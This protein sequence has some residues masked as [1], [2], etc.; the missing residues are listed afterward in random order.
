M[1]E[2]IVEIHVMLLNEGVT[3]AKSVMARALANGNYKILRPD[4]Y[5]PE[6]EEWEF[7]PGTI[8]HCEWQPKGWQEPLLMAVERV[9]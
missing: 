9:A 7:V 2:D 6:D 5:D 3:T 8:V 4:D 1:S